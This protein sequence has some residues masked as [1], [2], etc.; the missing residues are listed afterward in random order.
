MKWLLVFKELTFLEK[1]VR[2]WFGGYDVTPVFV[3]DGRV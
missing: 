2:L 1:D 3:I